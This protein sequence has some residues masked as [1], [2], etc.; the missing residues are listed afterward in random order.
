MPAAKSRGLRIASQKSLSKNL[1]Q[2]PR[3][4]PGLVPGF[5]VILFIDVVFATVLQNTHADQNDRASASAHQKPSRRYRKLPTRHIFTGDFGQSRSPRPIAS[6]PL[7]V[8]YL[9]QRSEIFAAVEQLTTDVSAGPENTC[10]AGASA[11]FRRFHTCAA[12]ALFLTPMHPP[13]SQR[14][15][16][17]LLRQNTSAAVQHLWR[18]GRA[19][20][21]RITNRVAMTTALCILALALGTSSRACSKK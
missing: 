19:Q 9:R 20:Y 3:V 10:A 18:F 7:C 5:F 12:S 8:G 1:G 13:E 11:R 16:K 15:S 6:K 14:L 2:V 17:C 4:A 21:R